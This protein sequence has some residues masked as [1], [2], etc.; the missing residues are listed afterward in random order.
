MRTF[1]LTLSLRV[2]RTAVNHAYFP[3]LTI[4]LNLMFEF[5]PIATLLALCLA[6]FFIDPLQFLFHMTAFLSRN[7]IKPMK[8]RKYVH[9]GKKYIDSISLY[10]QLS[11][12][13][14]SLS[15]IQLCTES[16]WCCSWILFILTGLGLALLVTLTLNFLSRLLLVT[17]FNTYFL[18]KPA[19]PSPA[20]SFKGLF[21]HFIGL[22]T[23]QNLWNGK[24]KICS[25]FISSFSN[26]YT[27]C[28]EKR[29]FL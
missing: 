25:V 20:T 28:L 17:H 4:I 19:Y 27:K 18:L 21:H 13:V 9:Q 2:V 12:C 7:R 3:T 15:F 16:I 14:L 6:I 29:S 5:T 26:L 24:K 23:F 8:S 22:N 1:N 10:I 11:Y